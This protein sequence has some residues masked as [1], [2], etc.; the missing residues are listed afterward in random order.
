MLLPHTSTVK[1]TLLSNIQ[2]KTVQKSSLFYGQYQYSIKF[3]QTELNVIRGLKSKRINTIVRDRNKWRQEH[4]HLYQ[5]RRELISD[6]TV[7]RL[8]QI[9]RLLEQNKQKLKFSVSYDRGYVYT[10][11]IDI[12][13]QINQLHFL[14]YVEAQQVCQSIPPGKILL[15]NPQWLYRTYFKS[16]V[17]DEQQRTNLVEFLKSREHVRLSPGLETWMEIKNHW[18][19]WVQSYFFIDHNDQGDVLFLNMIV[20]RITGRTLEIV[21][22]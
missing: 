7:S 19:D 10:N 3:T 22:K 1:D 18:N 5:Y 20:P 13:H 21:A 11:D 8:K 17:I 14:T 16:K 15:R 9:C 6:D 12:I 4:R 2:F